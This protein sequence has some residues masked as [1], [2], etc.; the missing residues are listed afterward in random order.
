MLKGT[1]IKPVLMTVKNPQDSSLVEW[2]HQVIFN[3]LVTRDIDKKFFDYIYTCGNTLTYISWTIISSNIHTIGT[4]T[5][6]DVFAR[7]MIFNITSVID[8]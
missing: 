5:V 3:M 8:W 7:D 1:D 6:H 2:V 4:K